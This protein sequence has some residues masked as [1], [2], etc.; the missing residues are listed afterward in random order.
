MPIDFLL[1]KIMSQLCRAVFV[2]ALFMLGI[3]FASAEEVEANHPYFVQPGDVLQISVWHEPEMQLDVL[4]RPDGGLS[5]P[6]IGEVRTTQRS[7]PQIAQEV[8]LRIGKFMPDVA[9]NVALKQSLGNKI[10]VLGMVNRP[11]EFVLNRSVDVMQA[12]SMASGT[13]KFAD[14]SA[15]KIIR[16]DEGQQKVM[17]FDYDDVVAGRSLEQNIVLRSG[18]TVVVP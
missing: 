8:S 4:V 7:I 2:V 14:V 9:V 18:D 5:L 16:R 11:G 10:Y 15:I 17:M 13:S 12:L 6:L 1:L 3:S